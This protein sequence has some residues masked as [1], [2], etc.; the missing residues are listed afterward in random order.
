MRFNK[1]LTNTLGAVMASLGSRNPSNICWFILAFLSTVKFLENFS[2]DMGNV[3]SGFL[4][5][6]IHFINELPETYESIV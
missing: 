6:T 3:I 1:I 2:P 5:K 4:W